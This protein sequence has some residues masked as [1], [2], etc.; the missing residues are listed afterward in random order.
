MPFR[1]LPITFTMSAFLLSTVAGVARA[2]A[3]GADATGTPLPRIGAT[4]VPLSNSGAPRFERDNTDE[5]GP[6]LA[7]VRPV[8][9]PTPSTAAIPK[10]DGGSSGDPAEPSSGEAAEARTSTSEQQKPTQEDGSSNADG[11][12]GSRRTAVQVVSTQERRATVR[13]RAKT[14]GRRFD[15][16]ERRSR[17]VV[18]NCTSE[19]TLDL[20]RGDY[21]LVIPESE[22]NARGTSRLTVEE[23]QTVTFADA[24]RDSSNTGL[25]LGIVGTVMIPAGLVIASLGLI[26]C[27]MAECSDEERDDSN[28]LALAGL[29]VLVGGVVL[30]PVG[31]SQFAR[32]R[33][34]KLETA[35]ADEQEWGVGVAALRG[36]GGLTLQGSF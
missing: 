18:A 10:R 28:T 9:P 16:Q 11:P 31:W 4:T 2:Q 7:S 15:V 17:A 35:R 21:L 3:L 29:G 14:S 1:I 22:G 36:G 20:P 8:P 33:R 12:S 34:P 19:C 6:R 13:L 24:D 27:G 5:V 30:T 32:N 26:H 23:D 25:A